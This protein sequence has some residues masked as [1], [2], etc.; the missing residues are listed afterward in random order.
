M[1]TKCLSEKNYFKII[2]LIL[3]STLLASC[4]ENQYDSNNLK[5]GKWTEYIIGDGSKETQK[6]SAEYIRKVIYDHGTPVGMGKD[7]YPNGSLQCEYYLISNNYKKDFR[8]KDKYKGLIV[9]FTKDTT[10]V[11]EWN[12]YD[13]YGNLDLKKYFITGFD[14]ISKDKRF[15]KKYFLST[16]KDFDFTLKLFDR[17]KNNPNKYDEDVNK[18]ISQIYSNPNLEKLIKNDAT[19][20]ML[21]VGITIGLKN[22]VTENNVDYD[23]ESRNENNDYNP[24]Y[25]D[26]NESSTQNYDR[27][28]EK[29]YYCNGTGKCSTCMKV[30]RVHYWAGRGPGW[31]DENQT[32][33]GQVMCD[34]CHGSGVIY[35]RHPLGEDP[36]YKKCYV[37]ACNNGWKTCPECNYN[38][39]GNN[40]G[41]CQRCK[42]SGIR[43]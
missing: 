17:Y 22:L 13:D 28:K 1:I 24:N 12:Y 3:F 32:R 25:S 39:N 5:D 7:Y 11:K 19:G 21:T 27:P 6:D 33:P 20:L 40:L 31:R 8:P 43:N 36:E 18:I 42:G 2:F 38:G 41:Q 9:W 16:N 15:D 37:S 10:N 30:F 26:P 35:G 34:D 4:Q 29:C 14:E 23:L